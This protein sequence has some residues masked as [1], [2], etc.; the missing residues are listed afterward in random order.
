MA[1]GCNGCGG[2]EHGAALNKSRRIYGDDNDTLFRLIAMARQSLGQICPA[3]SSKW[4]MPKHK[5]MMPK[6]G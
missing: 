6:H 2:G 1:A 4:V 3:I 5:W